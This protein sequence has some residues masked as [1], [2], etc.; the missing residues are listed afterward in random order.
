MTGKPWHFTCSGKVFPDHY[1]VGNPGGKNLSEPQKKSSANQGCCQTAIP[2][3]VSMSNGT[4]I[5]CHL[6]R[7]NQR[8]YEF[9]MM[10]YRRAT[11]SVVT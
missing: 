3:Q 7:I 2:L 1:G 4:D 5:N 10:L 11:S 8:K 9:E 6:D